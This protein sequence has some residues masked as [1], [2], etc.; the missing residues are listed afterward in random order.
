MS[1]ETFD[2]C[3]SSR[4]FTRARRKRSVAARAAIGNTWLSAGSTANTSLP[5]SYTGLGGGLGGKHPTTPRQT[6]S[7]IAEFR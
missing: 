4:P 1:S 3:G 2:I 7:R 5:G 6:A